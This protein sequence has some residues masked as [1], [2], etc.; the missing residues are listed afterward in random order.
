MMLRNWSISILGAAF[1]FVSDSRATTFVPKE[2]PTERPLGLLTLNDRQYRLSDF[3]LL[4][5]MLTDLSGL[6]AGGTRV[7]VPFTVGQTLGPE[8]H[9]L[10]VLTA[11]VHSENSTGKFWFRVLRGSQGEQV[12]AATLRV[13]IDGHLTEAAMRFRTVEHGRRQLESVN[14]DLKISADIPWVALYDSIRGLE[15][16]FASVEVG[17]C[18]AGLE[19]DPRRT[20]QVIEQMKRLSDKADS[21]GSRER[22]RCPLVWAISTRGGL[23]TLRVD[24]QERVLVLLEG[25]PTA[26]EHGPHRATVCVYRNGIPRR[27]GV[28]SFLRWNGDQKVGWG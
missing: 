7:K 1:F 3:E 6:E 5:G 13:V 8:R 10:F 2:S 19:V 9:G 23:M 16:T 20:L 12:R 26:T 25:L 15:S 17:R 18:V 22:E 24:E 28:K 27:H 4:V 21:A 14:P 11:V